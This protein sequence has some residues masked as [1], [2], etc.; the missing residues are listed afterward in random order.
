VLANATSTL[1]P[2][3]RNTW[4]AIRTHLVNYCGMTIAP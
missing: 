3:P 1:N 2:P 4:N